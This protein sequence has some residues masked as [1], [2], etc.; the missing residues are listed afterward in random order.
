MSLMSSWRTKLL[1]ATAVVA[2]L[3]S[4]A[5]L[6]LR[7]LPMHGKVDLRLAGLP[8]SNNGALLVTVVLSNG[9]SRAF[10]VVDDADGNPAFILDSGGELRMYLTRVVNQLTINLAPGASLTN[11]VVV[12]NPPPRFRLKVPLR[13]LGQTVNGPIDAFLPRPWA[14]KLQTWRRKPPP[15]EP[16]SAWIESKASAQ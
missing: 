4:L 6:L 11:T 5:L 13:D 14:A 12:T 8:Q 16:A 1:V 7:P 15:E 10:Y 3:L 9:T 2:L